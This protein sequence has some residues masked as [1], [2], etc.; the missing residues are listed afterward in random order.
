[1]QHSGWGM[2]CMRAG[3]DKA[4]L[5]QLACAACLRFVSMAAASDKRAAALH[6][7]VRIATA[8]LAGSSRACNAYSP[9]VS[10]TTPPHLCGLLWR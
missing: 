1:M 10:A 7:A 5:A 6:I 4:R 9:P 8:A 2:D 3:W